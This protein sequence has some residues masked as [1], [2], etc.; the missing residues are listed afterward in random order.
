LAGV[1]VVSITLSFLN[2]EVRNMSFKDLGN[3][4]KSLR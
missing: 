3:D 1:T 2:K 4:Q